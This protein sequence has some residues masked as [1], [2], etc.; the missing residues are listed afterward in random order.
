EV[1]TIREKWR[2]RFDVVVVLDGVLRPELSQV[3]AYKISPLRFDSLSPLSFEDGW[4]GLSVALA[5]PGF[6]LAITAQAAGPTLRPLLIIQAHSGKMNWAT[7]LNR[8]VVSANCSA[9]VA[10][11]ALGPSEKYLRSD[12]TVVELGVTSRLSF[13]RVQQD[14]LDSFHFSEVQARVASGAQ[15]HLAQLN[16]G[17]AWSRTSLRSQITGELGE[18]HVNG[19][20]FGRAHQHVDQRVEI[21]H[22]AANTVSSQLFK[23]VLKDSARGIL[24]GKIAIERDAQK[25]L[26][27]QMNH[28]LLLSKTAE[29]DT[30]PELEIYADDVKANHGA[31]VGRMDEEK[32]FYLMSRGIARAQAQQILAHA[33]VGDVL[34]KI[35]PALLREFADESVRGWLPDFMAG[36][37]AHV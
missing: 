26:S 24:N 21:R 4:G 22:S 34:M 14:S 25:V 3:G 5:R 7:S 35:E 29:A 10:C 1:E 12:M 23:G 16:G 15:L 36:M 18:C 6:D 2:L 19:L 20:T 11:L 8:I 32:L 31:S 28:N 30:K 9:E 13:V 17:S 37:E 33:F 27:S